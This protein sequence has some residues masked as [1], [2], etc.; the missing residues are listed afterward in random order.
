MEEKKSLLITVGASVA[1]AAGF[2]ALLYM[3]SGDIDTKRQNSERISGEIAQARA[4]IAATPEVERKVILMRETDEVISSLLPTNDDVLEFARALSSF[5]K[6]AG[7][8]ITQFRQKSNSTANSKQKEDFRKVG[9]SINFDADAFQMLALLD[10][11]E[12]HER[13]MQEIGRAHV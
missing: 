6:N 12:S 2:G 4:L 1:I 9:Y 5:G 10:R 11:V 3:Q 7:V 13:F 8:N